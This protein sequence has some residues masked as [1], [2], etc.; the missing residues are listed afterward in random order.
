MADEPDG[1]DESEF[2]F[3]DDIEEVIVE[4]DVVDFEFVIV[5]VPVLEDVDVF[6]D[7]IETENEDVLVDVFEFLLDNVPLSEPDELEEL[8]IE[9]VNILVNVKCG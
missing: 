4:L 2:V 6:E 9:Y 7:N 5:F 8:V 3:D 1:D